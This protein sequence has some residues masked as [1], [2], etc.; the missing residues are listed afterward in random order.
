MTGHKVKVKMEQTRDLIGEVAFMLFREKGFPTTTVEEI[1]AKAGVGARTV[2]RYYPT[3]EMLALSCFATMY[4]TALEDLRT[5][6]EDTAIPDVL[7]VILDS[8]LQSHLKRP[9]QFLTVYKMATDAPSV[10]AHLAHADRQWQVELQHE[11][12]YRMNGPSADLAAELAVTQTASVFTVAFR[13][14]FESD[15]QADLR[16]LTAEVLEL[17]RSGDVPMPAPML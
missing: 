14:W 5:C 4:E 10:H 11:V 17:L 1:A 6:P 16:K 15:G 8:V 3:K 2:Y 12:A 13:K 7:H 9:E